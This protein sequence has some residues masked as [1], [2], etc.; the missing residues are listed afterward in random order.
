MVNMDLVGAALAL[1]A[2]RRQGRRQARQRHRHSVRSAHLQRPLCRVQTHHPQG[3]GRGQR[4]GGKNTCT[5]DAQS[6]RTHGG[7]RM[8]SAACPTRQML[9][10]QPCLLVTCP[11]ATPAAAAQAIVYAYLRLAAQDPSCHASVDKFCELG[12]RRCVGLSRSQAGI[13]L[14]GTG[15]GDPASGWVQTRAAKLDGRTGKGRV[16]LAP[17]PSTHRRRLFFPI[18]VRRVPAA[19]D[20]QTVRALRS[21]WPALLQPGLDS[22]SFDADAAWPG[23]R[24]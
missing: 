9:I 14:N 3:H 6:T 10:L 5:G 11:V 17:A 4:C 12:G 18:D 7:Q 15:D 16:A 23:Q 21:C 13:A 1:C 2:C 8:L 20:C 22:R 24:P 19:A